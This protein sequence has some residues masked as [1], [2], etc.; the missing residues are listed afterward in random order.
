MNGKAEKGVLTMIQVIFTFSTALLLSSFSLGCTQT[1]HSQ[2]MSQT[3]SVLQQTAAQVTREDFSVT[4]DPNIQL[5]VRAVKP[6]ANRD[7]TPILLLHGGGGGGI[8]SY[9]VNVSGYSLA[10]T[11]ANAG[12]PTYLMNVRGWERSTRPAGLSQ[13]NNANPPLVQSEEVVRDI[14]AVV[15]AIQQRH[16]NQAVALVGHAS[17]GHWA[18]MYTSRNP[19]KISALVML[20]S[21]YGVNAPWEL[22]QTF[23]SKDNPG[24]FNL[25]GAAYREVTAEGLITNWSNNI[26]VEDKTQWRDPAVA[27][28]YQTLTFENDSTSGT[29]QPP[30]VRIP[31]GF[32]LDAYNLSRGQK[33]WN[34]ADIRVPTLVIRGDRDHWSRQ[35]DLQALN[36]EL[37]NARR[38]K[39]VT[40]P[41]GTH[42]L[43]LDRPERGRD[44]FV[45]EVLSFLD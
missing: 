14:S 27:Q 4:S 17:G 19:D 32:R 26:P 33:L 21:L 39:M 6:T 28:A 35:V 34:A 7:R 36:A 37:V 16:Q 18:G 44:R 42:F 43:F 5:F 45:Q 41:D 25:D 20:N 30:S 12:H 1:T 10:E 24:Q 13:A 9:D 31:G 3:P 40:I 2:T 8:A 29:R 23:E 38:K 15:D 22:R 11:F